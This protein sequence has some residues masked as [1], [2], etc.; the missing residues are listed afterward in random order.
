VCDSNSPS[1]F[2]DVGK[3]LA[4]ESS[5]VIA[6]TPPHSTPEE[7]TEVGGSNSGVS[8]PPIGGETE[9]S[10]GSS[11][12]SCFGAEDAIGRDDFFFVG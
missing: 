9:M 2:P 10:G 5:L 11:E 1:P 6:V 8:D 4:S 7:G 12:V 3:E